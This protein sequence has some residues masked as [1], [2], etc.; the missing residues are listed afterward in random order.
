MIEYYNNLYCGSRD[1]FFE[2][3]DSRA[4]K[5][6]KTFVVTANPET[7]MHGGRNPEFHALLTDKDTV[8]TP[9]GIGVVKAAG[10]LGTP[11]PERV[12]GF[13]L[14]CRVIEYLN[15]NK[16]SLFIL[17]GKPGVAETAFRLRIRADRH[18]HH[19]SS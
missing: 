7:F 11:L 5:G 6:E 8:I 3:I 12:G 17:G 15:E 13:D 4:E 10:I 18:H 2:F 1:E 16:M 9:D 14:T 19:I